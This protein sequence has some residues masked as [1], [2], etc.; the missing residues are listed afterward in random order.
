[1]L[2][3]IVETLTRLLVAEI[4][5]WEQSFTDWNERAKDRLKIIGTNAYLLFYNHPNLGKNI[6]ALVDFKSDEQAARVN[7]VPLIKIGDRIYMTIADWKS[8]P[9]T[10]RAFV[11]RIEDPADLQHYIE[12]IFSKTQDGT[13]WRAA[14]MVHDSGDI[15]KSDEEALGLS[16]EDI[17]E[18]FIDAFKSEALAIWGKS[19]SVP[20][21]PPTSDEVAQIEKLLKDLSEEAAVPLDPY[22][23]RARRQKAENAGAEAF[24]LG[25]PGA[26]EVAEE[27]ELTKGMID[28][29][30]Q[31]VLEAWELGWTRARDKAEKDAKE[32]AEREA[33][34]KKPISRLT[35]TMSARVLH[36]IIGYVVEKVNYLID[37]AYFHIYEDK[38]IVYAI[39]SSH[40]AMAKC[41]LLKAS[42]PDWE[43]IGEHF[44]I[45]MNFN[46]ILKI[47]R[48]YQISSQEEID[49]VFESK[50]NVM[51]I[52]GY[53]IKTKEIPGYDQKEE[54]LLEDFEETLKDKYRWTFTKDITAAGDLVQKAI[55]IS[56]LAKFTARERYTMDE[57]IEHI[58]AN[59]NDGPNSKVTRGVISSSVTKKGNQ[60]ILVPYS[61]PRYEKIEEMLSREFIGVKVEEQRSGQF[62][63][64]IPKN[65][66]E[67]KEPG[68]VVITAY[69]ES[70]EFENLF[71]GATTTP[72]YGDGKPNAESSRV[73]EGIFSLN[74]LEN[75]IKVPGIASKTKEAKESPIE[76]FLGNNV[77][78]KI[79]QKIDEHSRILWLLAPRV[80]DQPEDVW[81]E[82]EGKE[83]KEE[84]EGAQIA[85]ILGEEN[86]PDVIETPAT[87]EPTAGSE[88]PIEAEARMVCANGQ[89]KV[90]PAKSYKAAMAFLKSRSRY[91][92]E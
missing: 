8:E 44:K 52:A 27:K 67:V 20:I 91:P 19:S 9:D 17:S 63:V 62:S 43:F 41:Y 12:L 77:P 54:G 24:K 92:Q 21:P 26:P 68:I 29:E 66:A 23:L 35:L 47:I 4:D 13:D 37:E 61:E 32:A 79:N 39:D 16:I 1:M 40:V 31:K 25:K 78:V 11:F 53:K 89:C 73:G 28:A 7:G 22:D 60:K 88:G 5:P 76:I 86:A 58:K 3:E 36:N 51:K 48:R 65:I 30:A 2:D 83:I 84:S 46:D 34:R 80:E 87:E 14:H 82:E 18:F 72:S 69:D 71:S 15:D 50:G 6:V 85:E 56:D 90:K 59:V 42:F 49:V 74:F 45:G 64:E 81:E 55:V 33:H 70:G 57:I 10:Y 38:I 75:I